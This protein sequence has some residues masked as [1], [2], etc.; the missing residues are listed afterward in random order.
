MNTKDLV[1]R[2]Y[3]TRIAKI[4]SAS[5]KEASISYIHIDNPEEYLLA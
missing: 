3:L 5:T 4:A 2:D 1:V